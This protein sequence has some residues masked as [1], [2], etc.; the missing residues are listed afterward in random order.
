MV[1]EA[2]INAVLLFLAIVVVIW[3]GDRVAARAA[4]RKELHRR[5]RQTIVRWPDTYQ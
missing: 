1:F 5:A 4:R 3:L 2:T